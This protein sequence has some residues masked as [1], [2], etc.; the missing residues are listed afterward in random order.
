MADTLIAATLPEK[1]SIAIVAGDVQKS[2]LL[3]AIRWVDADL[4]MPPKKKLGAEQIAD[5]ESWIQKGATWGAPPKA[6]AGKASQE[7]LRQS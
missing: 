2:L 6:A 7:I 4:K 5:L 1:A 3:K